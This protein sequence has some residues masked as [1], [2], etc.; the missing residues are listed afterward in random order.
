MVQPFLD[1]QIYFK[2]QQPEPNAAPFVPGNLP[3]NTVLALVTDSFTSATERHIEVGDG[4][5][6]YVVCKA[7]REMNDLLGEGALLA[8]MTV[9]EIPGQGET[10]EE[11][12]FLVRRSLK[13]D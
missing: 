12:T 4:L 1:N 9:E 2:N 7:G 10:L 5:E 13:R 11:R 3:L 8:G 6:V